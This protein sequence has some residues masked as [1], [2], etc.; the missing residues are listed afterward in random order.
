MA[1]TLEGE[2]Y[3]FYDKKF[4]ETI[5]IKN[6]SNIAIL[7]HDEL[8]LSLSLHLKNRMIYSPTCDRNQR[9]TVNPLPLLSLPKGSPRAT[10]ESIR[11][12]SPLPTPIQCLVPIN[13]ANS[14]SNKLTSCPRMYQPLRITLV[15]AA[16]NSSMKSALASNKLSYSIILDWCISGCNIIIFIKVGR[17]HH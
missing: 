9:L 7:A 1:I 11:A 12:S 14:S 3:I 13:F 17:R 16:S 10:I 5:S 8:P 4:L 2:R 15:D 6:S